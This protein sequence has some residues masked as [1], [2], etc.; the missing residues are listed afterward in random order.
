MLRLKRV[1][2][3]SLST[4]GGEKQVDVPV[5]L[6]ARVHD[7]ASRVVLNSDKMLSELF[8]VYA[9]GVVNLAMTR[10]IRERVKVRR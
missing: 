2:Y 5:E 8:N 1:Y 9:R 3:L 6:R 7:L 10:D 4:Y